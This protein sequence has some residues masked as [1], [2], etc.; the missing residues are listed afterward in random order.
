MS[1]NLLHLHR[2]PMISPPTHL[3]IQPPFIPTWKSI[4]RFFSIFLL[5]YSLMLRA[6]HLTFSSGEKQREKERRDQVVLSAT[7]RKRNEIPNRKCCDTI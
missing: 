5:C 4:E 2:N 1:F 7:R 3:I 6:F